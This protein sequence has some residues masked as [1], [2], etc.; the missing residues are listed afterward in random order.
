MACIKPEKLNKNAA[1]RMNPFPKRK[2]DSIKVQSGQ[3]RA[4]SPEGKARRAREGRRRR[5][6]REAKE[7]TVVLRGTFPSHLTR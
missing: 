2:D 3:S 6:E 1:Q 5:R 4:S 7:P